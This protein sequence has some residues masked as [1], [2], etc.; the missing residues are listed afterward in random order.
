MTE[1]A[2]LRPHTPPTSMDE[3]NAMFAQNSYVDGFGPEVASHV[4][5]PFCAAPNFMTLK[6]MEMALSDDLTF[7]GICEECGRSG[8]SVMKRDASGSAMNF[9]QT[10]GDDPPP[11][12]QPPP[13]DARPEAQPE[14]QTEVQP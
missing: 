2:G 12:L 6:P 1:N 5:C 7:E 14:A 11:W 3:Y 9:E 4:A 13:P 10:G 8:R